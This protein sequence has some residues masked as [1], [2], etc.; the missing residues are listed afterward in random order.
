MIALDW[1]TTS[2]RGWL[3]G[4]GGTVLDRHAAASGIMA[5]TDGNFDAA[6]RTF[7]AGWR[8]AQPALP[9]L[10]SGMIG[11]RQGWVEAPYVACPAGL[12]DLAGRGVMAGEAEAA[13]RIVPG[14]S[15]RA[16]DGMT[17]VMRGE[18][19][20]IIG[21]LDDGGG[22]GL[23]VLPGTHSKW[24]RVE[25]GRIVGFATYMTGE[26]FA[27]LRGHSILGRM[28]PADGAMAHDSRT[29]AAGVADG[30]D[31]GHDLP[32]RLFGVRT[33]GLFGDLGEP[34]APSFL[35][36]LLIGAELAGARASGQIGAGATAATLIGETT[37]CT[38]YAE[39]LAMAGIA[40]RIADADV[41]PRGLWRLACAAG[42]IDT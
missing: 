17:D 24:A 36:G 33:R 30:L 5:V 15:W 10:A 11:S 6:Y 40:A 20:Q 21:A 13:L 1:G 34:A 25:G 37:L 26:L 22:D 39:A 14:L 27:V 32:R 41:T 35:S 31:H 7:T 16:P 28:M 29:F 42:M 19:S 18:E 3:L 9:A 4:D 2:L 23:F 12:A 8:A 38:R